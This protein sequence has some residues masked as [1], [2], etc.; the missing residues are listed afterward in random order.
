[1][2]AGEEFVKKIKPIGCALFLLA[3]VIFFV[4]AFTSGN[5]PIEGYEAP[6]TTEYY[7]A[8]LAELESELEQNVLPHIDAAV[9][10]AVGEG[11]VVVT[12]R[13]RGFAAARGDI[14]HYF[15]KSLFEFV[16]E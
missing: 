12:L 16:K 5:A 13:E 2:G 1:M 9:D 6:Q 7:A 11:V 14:L 4:Y 10:C 3:M 8:H 15:D